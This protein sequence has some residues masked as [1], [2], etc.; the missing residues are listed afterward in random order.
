MV[1][2]VLTTHF[3]FDF[4]KR[5]LPL[6]L[7]NP[8]IS[9]IVVSDDASDDA[10]KIISADLFCEERASGRL[11]LFIQPTNRGALQNK[12]KVCSLAKGPWICLM[13]SDNFA[14]IDYFDAF[15]TFIENGG[16]NQTIYAPQRGLSNFDFTQ[17][18]GRVFNKNNFG[19][20]NDCLMNIGNY[21]MHKE[22]VPLLQSV[23]LSIDPFALDVKYL[24]H[25]VFEHGGSLV[26][27]P[28]MQYLHTQHTGSWYVKTAAKSIAF[29]KSFNW[30]FSPS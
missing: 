9:E 21:I 20:M 16:D 22:L 30:G 2:L 3:R 8:L 14:D 7:A 25:H 6:Y 1:S 10:K 27:V 18:L 5:N 26:V 23:D 29:D 4:L 12:I 24:L 11:R 13:D 19:A 15:N 17:D 28:G